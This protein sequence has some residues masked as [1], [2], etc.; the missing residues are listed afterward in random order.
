MA[1]KR[2]KVRKR[3][4]RA[5]KS[6]S[7]N[8]LIKALGHPVRVEALSVLTD[9]VASPKEIAAAIG[10]KL[11]NVSYHVRVLDELGFVEIVEEESV[12]GSVAH[13]YDLVDRDV[14]SNSEWSDLDPTVRTAFSDYIIGAL[15]ADLTGSAKCGVLDRRDDRLLTR[16]PLRLDEAGWKKA[17]MIQTAAHEKILKVQ[18]EADARINRSGRDPILAVLGQLLFEVPPE[19]QQVE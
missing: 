19:E 16:T 6:V 13:F 17:Q 18:A 15:L 9:R 7:S 14:I 11:S 1:S 8:A 4:R 5:S 3:H 10:K 2:R 12:R